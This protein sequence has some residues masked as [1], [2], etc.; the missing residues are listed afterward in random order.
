MSME[1]QDKKKEPNKLRE[2]TRAYAKYSGMAFQLL[3]AII[4]G[5]LIGKKLDAYFQ[6]ARPYMTAVS[7]LLFLLAGLYLS[8]KDFLFKRKK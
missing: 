5:V 7:A 8:L 4:I 6:F 3:A 1:T 2:K